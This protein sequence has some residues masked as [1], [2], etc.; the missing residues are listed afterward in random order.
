M[1]DPAE[2]GATGTQSLER[3]IALLRVIAGRNATGAR[4]TEIVA[5]SGLKK[6]TAHRLLTA[7]VRE[8]LVGQERGNQR[9]HL[10]VELF[11][12][13]VTASS[14]F[15]IRRFAAPSL[16]RLAE[17]SADTVY[18]SVRSNMEAV[19]I[20]RSEGS[21]PIKTLTLAAGDRRPLGVGAGSLAILAALPDWE[22][23][24]AIAAA[25]PLLPRY[26]ETLTPAMLER[27]IA[28]ARAEGYA[29]ND[30][31]IIEG[32]C[33]VGVPIRNS[34]GEAV[35]SLS[36]AAIRSRMRP[37]RRADLVA[38]L[39]REAA[40]IEQELRRPERTAPP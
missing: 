31:L 34:E 18:L 26:S 33:A 14:R 40:A 16:G 39:R 11:T 32:M 37:D 7:L 25:A 17:L 15:G 12:L 8:G 22:R 4:L 3:A 21:F 24:Q 36:I 1:T 29:F 9:Y 13:G 30:G 27:Q 23:A 6:A 38:A 5:A 2:S 35:A 10:G 19:C 28:E 20:E